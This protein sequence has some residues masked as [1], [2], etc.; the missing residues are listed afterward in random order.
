MLSCPSKRCPPNSRESPFL[1]GSQPRP[2][3]SRPQPQPTPRLSAPPGPRHR[4]PIFIT[5]SPR[6]PSL[7]Q[8]FPP[9][10]SV[11]PSRCRAKL[12]P[13]T[14]HTYWIYVPAQY[15]PAIPASLMI[16][17]D[18]QAFM[19]PRRR[20]ARAVCDGQSDLP[21]RDSGDD[22]G[23]HQSGPPARS[24]GADCRATGAIAI[25]TG[26]PSTTLSTTSTPA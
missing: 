24:A 25:R 4:T 18:G 6:M 21:A 2:S 11:D 23:V 3:P 14:Q 10:R 22:R 1:S 9:A 20:Y 16:Y 26:P 13:G 15:D 5:S 7:S 19:A 17:N 8:E 12:I